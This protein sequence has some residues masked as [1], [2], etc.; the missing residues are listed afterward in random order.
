ME[1]LKLLDNSKLV[2]DYEIQNFRKWTGGFYYKL[3]II[4]A[5]ED[6]LFAKEYYD[7]EE[8]T[9]YY[10]WLM[11]RFGVFFILYDNLK[12]YSG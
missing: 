2:K 4:F 9:R 10:S 7:Y 11:L 12:P 5:N 3:K 1:I 6:A 8:E